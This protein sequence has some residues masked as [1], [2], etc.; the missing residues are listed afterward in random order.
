MGLVLPIRFNATLER[1]L[2]SIFARYPLFRGQIAHSVKCQLDLD[3]PQIPFHH[4]IFSPRA[5]LRMAN[6]NQHSSIWVASLI[7]LGV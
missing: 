1:Y 2:G 4:A 6:K 3:V 5:N 7:P